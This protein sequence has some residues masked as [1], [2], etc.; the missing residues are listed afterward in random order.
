MTD[1]ARRLLVAGLNAMLLALACTHARAQQVVRIGVSAPL[2]GLNAANGKDIENGV[3]LAV[4]EAN[5]RPIRLDGHAVRVELA[6]GDDQSDPRIGV[7]VAQKLVDDGVAAVIGYYNSGVALPAGPVFAR[8]GIPVIHPAATNPAITRQ[9]LGTVFR[10]IPTDAQNSGNAGKY[11]VKAMQAHRIA[12]MDD[13]TAFGHGAVDEFKKAVV[14]AGGKIAIAEYAS[15]KTVEF[16]AQLTNIRAANADVLFFAG[17]D[18]QAALVTKRMR[19]LGM[20]TQF[21]GSGG[22]ADSIFLKIAGPAAEGAMAWEYGRP[23]DSLPQGRAF[24]QKFRKRFGSDSLS[25]APFAYDATWVVIQAMKD[26]GSAKP[27]NYVP[28]VRATQYE[29]AT[30]TIAFDGNGDLRHPAST[31]YQVK[32]GR[33]TAVT[34]IAIE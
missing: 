18:N 12:V 19:E 31:L 22:I 11:V 27:A 3:R 14:A 4:E 17:L 33:W 21:V 34:T 15:D 29:G 20:R 26:A 13:R 6:T 32:G 28:A 8:A 2:T 16:S 9:G 7:Q 30:G 24:L 23:L 10:V 25:Y 1:F 5:A